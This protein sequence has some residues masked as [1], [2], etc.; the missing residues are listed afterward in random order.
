MT[1]SNGRPFI[2]ASINE[3]NGVSR[4]IFPD[5]QGKR[6]VHGIRTEYDS[7]LDKYITVYKDK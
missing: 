1:Y 4:G 3:E 7:K 2:A 5:F 6:Y